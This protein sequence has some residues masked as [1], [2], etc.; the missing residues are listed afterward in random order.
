MAYEDQFVNS[1]AAGETEYNSQAEVNEAEATADAYVVENYA[2]EAYEHKSSL[3]DEQIKQLSKKRISKGELKRQWI[4]LVI[5]LIFVLYG[6]LF[7]YLPLG[8]WIMAFQNFKLKTGLLHSKFV[9]FDKFKFM[10]EFDT[11]EN[12]TF[13]IGI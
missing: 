10:F 7:Y 11:F 13:T 8:G 2:K 6:L 1:G 3:N 9:G 12:I 5:G 4:L